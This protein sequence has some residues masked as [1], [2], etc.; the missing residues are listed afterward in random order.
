MISEDL[1][2][3]IYRIIQEQLNNVV[4]HAEA[5]NVQISLKIKKHNTI[6]LLIKD[7]GIGCD[8]SIHP[9]GVGLQNINTRAALH[10]GV[11]S[12]ISTPT[13]GFELIVDFPMDGGG[14]A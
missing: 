9:N 14:I 10:N 5:N 13:N 11:V 2:L 3:M 12:L 4:K 7:D 6:Q 8:L 1:K